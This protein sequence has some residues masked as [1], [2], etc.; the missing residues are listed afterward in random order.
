MAGMA[1]TEEEKLY[2]QDD[3]PKGPPPITPEEMAYVEG[4]EPPTPPEASFGDQAA[5][6]ARGFGQAAVDVV[7][8]PYT[9]EHLA[10][11]GL[12][13]AGVEGGLPGEVSTTK[14]SDALPKSVKDFISKEGENIEKGSGA[15]L[16]RTGVEWGAGGLQGA[17]KKS[18][19]KMLPDL[20][21][22]GG[23]AG[24]QAAGDWLGGEAGGDTGELIGGVVGVI[25]AL[26]TGKIEGLTRSQREMLEKLR[27]QFDSPEEAIAAMQARVNTGELG[28]L[29]DLSGSRNIANAEAALMRTEKGAKEIPKTLEARAN[30]IYD[31]TMESISSPELIPEGTSTTLAPLR[32]KE[33]A[34]ART[35]A[36][37][38]DD[39][40]SRVA[41]DTEVDNLS[42]ALNTEVTQ[43]KESA[44]LAKAAAK[45]AKDVA[46]AGK[47]TVDPGLRPDQYSTSASG[48]YN[49]AEKADKAAT[50]KLYDIFDSGPGITSAPF[51]TEAQ[52]FLA[53]MDPAEAAVVRAK[54]GK[55]FDAIDDFEPTVSPRGLSLKI[56]Q[57]K[58]D[59][60]NAYKNNVAGFEEVKLREFYESFEEALANPAVSEGYANAVAAYK[61][62]SEM[63]GPGYIKGI[64]HTAEPEEFFSQVG[65]TGD[66]GAASAKLL[67]QS[68]IPGVKNDVAD[69][70]KAQAVRK[71]D[72]NE[73]FLVEYEAV[74]DNLD[75]SV[76]QE[77]I[78]LIDARAAE[79]T[80]LSQAKAADELATRT[81]DRA[82]KE[83]G[84]L[85]KALERENA[86]ITTKTEKLTKANQ[87]AI[88]TEYGKGFE[89]ADKVVDDILTKPDG[90]E[91]LLELQTDLLSTDAAQGGS[92]TMESFHAHV[93]DRVANQLF[94]LF[95][96]GGKAPKKLKVDALERFRSM[97]RRLGEEGLIDTDT[98][99]YID[100][101]LG[102]AQTDVLRKQGSATVGD[103]TSADTEMTNLFSSLMSAI[104]LAPLP[105]G[106][107]LQ[108]GGAVRR[109]FKNM[110]DVKPTRQNIKAL[111][112]FM[113]DP[114]AFLK[115]MDALNTPAAKQKFFLTKLVGAAQAAEILGAE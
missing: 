50:Q 54:Y 2:L 48:K 10:D 97:Q 25:A 16:L 13:F 107:N 5:H 105:G 89:Q 71:A 1:L 15:D 33:T 110:L 11:S 111:T 108:L 87:R 114:E 53:G 61:A 73:G 49:A 38:V 68:R 66:R 34:A 8:L 7:D 109:N 21:A 64:R 28:T 85:N 31:E 9:L 30:Q 47:V 115:G 100:G 6:V 55:Y 45:E 23:A 83:Q 84:R 56:Q 12:K 59:V 69:Y 3:T 112:E 101:V 18:L 62:G 65:L 46:A 60:A 92:K 39:T 76:R 24:G 86:K 88:T 43:T 113:T 29:T 35:E 74:L 103:L 75:P 40:A 77:V 90:V 80:G 4:V 81:T 82:A 32:A 99:K 63:Y 79:K 72:L 42:Q 52:A 98:S 70:V 36:I 51:K 26:R 17:V 44:R 96:P 102:R 58:S 104:T 14:I 41:A 27:A 95:E 78:A 67:E 57:M 19:R 37:A 91:Q 22:G 93:R 106:Y 20:L 94:E